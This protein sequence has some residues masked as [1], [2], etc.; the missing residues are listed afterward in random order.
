[1][2]ADLKETKSGRWDTTDGPEEYSL[3][4]L[5]RAVGRLPDGELPMNQEEERKSEF[6]EDFD[7]S[8]VMFWYSLNYG[9]FIFYLNNVCRN[10]LGL[11]SARLYIYQL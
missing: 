11:D 9:V 10:R 3:K 2:V 6:Y 7:D 5:I 1:M 4:M 8:V